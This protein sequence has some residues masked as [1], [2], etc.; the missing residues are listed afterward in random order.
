MGRTEGRRNAVHTST[1]GFAPRRNLA[2]IAPT[3]LEGHDVADNWYYLEGREQRGPMSREQLL[4]VLGN[5]PNA[6]DTFVWREGMGDWKRA[7]DVAELGSAPPPFAQAG[8]AP[9]GAP[10]G[11]T[12]ASGPGTGPFGGAG[13]PYGAPMEPAAQPSILNLWFGFSGR[14]NRA[15]YWLVSLVNTGL[16]LAAL[17]MIFINVGMS[18]WS[19]AGVGVIVLV[20]LFVV[21]IVSGIAVGIKRLHD[22]DKSGWWILLFY[23]VPSILS[24]GGSASGSLGAQGVL[25]LASLALSIWGIV[26]LGFLRGTQGPNQYGP[27]PLQGR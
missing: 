17:T 3:N 26:E 15:K 1:C 19:Q 7:G 11:F 23:V 2:S 9:M 20:V 6:R 10:G 13:A 12:S 27:D 24:S 5:I 22:R 21:A 18:S 8:A 14:V 25:G 4:G 16:L